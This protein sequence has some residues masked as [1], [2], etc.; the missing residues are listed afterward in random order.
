MKGIKVGHAAWGF[1]VMFAA[2]RSGIDA[3]YTHWATV[4]AS[5]VALGFWWEYHGQFLVEKFKR[6]RGME[7]GDPNSYLREALAFPVGALIAQLLVWIS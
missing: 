6:W 5:T 4:L 7:E 3:W 2:R 1:A